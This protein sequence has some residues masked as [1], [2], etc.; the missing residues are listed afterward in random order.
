MRKRR[1]CHASSKTSSPFFLGNAAWPDMSAISRLGTG[2][3]E[4]PPR[5]AGRGGRDDR[6]AD[7]R[8][9]RDQLRERGLAQAFGAGG[10]L[11]KNQVPELGARVPDPDLHALGQVDAE[12][13]QH[14]ARLP[15]RAGAVLER[16]VPD[17][18]E[19]GESG[20][21]A[22]GEGADD[23]GGGAGGGVD[24]PEGGPPPAKLLPARRP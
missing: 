14:H 23:E 18:R 5:S 10:P 11:R 17:W 9:T 1:P 13:A 16:L 6:H 15:Y 12:L 3:L 22:G 7:H 4:P 2:S 24:H 21:V 8:V 19:A 20:R